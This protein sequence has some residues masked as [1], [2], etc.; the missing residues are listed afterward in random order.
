MIE[1][2]QLNK[3]FRFLTAMQL[4]LSEKYVNFVCRVELIF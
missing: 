3:Y 1:M 4:Y 2:P